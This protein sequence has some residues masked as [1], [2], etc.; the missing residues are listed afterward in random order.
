M[1]KTRKAGKDHILL[2]MFPF[3]ISK[4]TRS[5]IN[6]GGIAGLAQSVILPCIQSPVTARRKRAM[7]CMGLYC[8]LSEVS[9]EKD[10]LHPLL[11]PLSFSL[12]PSAFLSFPSH[13]SHLIFFSSPLLSSSFLTVNFPLWYRLRRVSSFPF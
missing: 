1:E 4:P 8:L 12:P 13:P 10:D 3:S 9:K 6:S 7:L 2:F 5:G 11:L